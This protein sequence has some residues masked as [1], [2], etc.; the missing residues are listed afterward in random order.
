METIKTILDQSLVIWKESTGAGRVGI[1]LLLLIAVGAI[2]GVGYWSSMPDYVTLAADLDQDKS[3]KLIA[4]L[5]QDNIAFRIK[6]ARIIQ[7][8]KRQ[9]DRAYAVA[10]QVGVGGDQLKMETIYPWMD[11]VTQHQAD[12]R[13]KERNL[14]QSLKK[15][16]AIESAT[17]LLSIPE[18]QP[19][20]RQSASPS[21][22]VLLKLA[23]N[24]QFNEGH[25]VAIAK[26]VAGSVN[27]LRPE[28]VVITDT[29]NNIYSIDESLAQL[30]KQEQFRVSREEENRT[31]IQSVLTPIF[32]P[33]NV[34]VQ[35]SMDFTFP[36]ST[37]TSTE[38][39]PDKKVAYDEV[40]ESTTTTQESPISGGTATSGGS[41][42][43]KSNPKKPGNKSEI[44]N[45]KYEVQKTV[46]TEVAKTPVLN[47][48]SISVVINTG[49][50]K[51]K[52][53]FTEAQKE[54]IASTIKNSVNFKEEWSDNFS[55]DFSSFEVKA[56]FE[57]V[58]QSTFPW[59]QLFSALKMLSLGIA[60]V[61]ALL[62]GLKTLKSFQPAT[63]TPDVSKLLS[64]DRKSQ[65]M[66]LSELVKQNPE[67]FSKIV[68][69]W[70]NENQPS[71]NKS[72]KKAA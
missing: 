65:V 4:G 34:E 20:L 14:T 35:V 5:D 19:F 27:G 68:A 52:R 25:A 61:V 22:S 38:F 62:F 10:Q 58:P 69:S 54:K 50:G 17:V 51:A 21:A 42:A 59:E 48:M 7:V 30:S 2:V 8:D 41:S 66:E 6:G 49:T 13:N 26:M 39:D 43:G 18:P 31:K 37:T 63:T 28:Q 57:A 45:S 46:R 53:E 29:S 32:G 23:P 24:K 56:P 11:P 40:V 72:D 12:V 55:L 47:D 1:I 71:T 70:A 64:S 15:Y 16:S 33:T 67:V 9:L 60:A 3:S 36:D 44:R